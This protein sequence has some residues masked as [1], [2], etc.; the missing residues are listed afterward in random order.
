MKQRI[1]ELDA[2]R[3]SCVLGMVLV[4]LVYDAAELY[5]LIDWEYPP[6]F[7]L[8]KEYGGILFIL[9][10]GICASFGSRPALRGAN[11]LACGLLCTLDG[12]QRFLGI[13]IKVHNHPSFRFLALS[14]LEC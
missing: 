3:G 12:F 14:S 4:H 11:I 6:F 8:V 2:L 10:S 1:W 13:V 9:I 5:G 7:H